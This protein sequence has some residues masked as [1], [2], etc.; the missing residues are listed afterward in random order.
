MLFDNS[1]Q[2]SVLVR[3][4][5]AFFLWYSLKHF[6]RLI[7]LFLHLY[8]PI[9]LFICLS[10]IFYHSVFIFYLYAIHYCQHFFLNQRMKC[11]YYSLCRITASLW[12][13]FK[14]IEITYHFL[15]LHL[16]RAVIW[17]YRTD[18]ASRL[19]CNDVIT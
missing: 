15:S 17:T 7:T 8:W 2:F 5:C 19:R 18:N 12:E 4:L 9:C 14:A 1:Y 6:R 16:F 11:S 3:F 10:S 13:L